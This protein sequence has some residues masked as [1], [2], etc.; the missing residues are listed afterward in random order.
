MT[1]GDSSHS[2]R[3][4]KYLAFAIGGRPNY[5]HGGT[6][7]EEVHVVKKYPAVSERVARYLARPCI[8]L[9]A[10]WVIRINSL[11][12]FAISISSMDRLLAVRIVT[13]I[14]GVTASVVPLMETM[15]MPTNQHSESEDSVGALPPRSQLRNSTR[16][17]Y[18]H[19]VRAAPFCHGCSVCRKPPEPMPV[20]MQVFTCAYNTKTVP[21]LSAL[22]LF[23][24]A[25][26]EP[27]PKLQILMTV[28]CRRLAKL[29][30]RLGAS[31]P[32]GYII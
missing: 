32:R 21:R 8:A 26:V 17:P 11:A 13:V 15:S 6:R 19:V 29:P 25:N 2:P 10:A 28:M 20:V 9:L 27:I 24:Y 22:P 18:V 16:T 7:L 1:S 3:L 12:I 23:L 31:D 4:R 14:L 5:I 30:G